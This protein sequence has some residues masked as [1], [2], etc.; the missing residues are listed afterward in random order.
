MPAKSKKQS[1]FLNWEFDH[2]WVKEHHFDNS[3]KGLPERVSKG[4]A[5]NKK[6]K[7]KYG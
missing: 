4:A 3:T 2:E 5:G 7:R 1:R 6:L